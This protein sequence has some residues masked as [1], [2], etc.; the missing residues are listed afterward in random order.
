MRLIREAFL[1]L[2]F[3][4]CVFAFSLFCEGMPCGF[5]GDGSFREE[6][7]RAATGKDFAKTSFQTWGLAR[8]EKIEYLLRVGALQETDDFSI[9]FKATK[10]SVDNAMLG[11]NVWLGMRKWHDETPENRLPKDG[12]RVSY[13]YHSRFLR[14]VI[15]I[16]KA[17]GAGRPTPEREKAYLAFENFDGSD[18]ETFPNFADDFDLALANAALQKQVHQLKKS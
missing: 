13:K 9:Y 18:P 16:A 2:L 1:P 15:E 5:L 7:A 8:E 12:D 6:L 10:Q 17:N 14:R 4:E 11:R 3:S